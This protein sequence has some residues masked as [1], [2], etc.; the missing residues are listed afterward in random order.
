MRSTRHLVDPELLASLDA[1]PP[2][3]FNAATLEKARAA[4]HEP[5][6]SI[7]LHAA[8]EAVKCSTRLVSG[9]NEAPGVSLR[10]YQPFEKSESTGCIYHMHGGGYLCGNAAMM[11][12]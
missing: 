11:E 10:I 1:N 2:I 4:L 9:P 5:F 8:D 7:A 12:P 3:R 6:K